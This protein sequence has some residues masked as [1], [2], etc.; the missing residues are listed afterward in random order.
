MKCFRCEKVL[1]V[2]TFKKDNF[3]CKCDY[4]IAAYKPSQSYGQILAESGF[5]L[6]YRNGILLLRSTMAKTFQKM[7]QNFNRVEDSMV[8]DE[9]LYRELE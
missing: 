2:E 4:E 3:I 9:T 6:V 1:V 8:V 5:Y 7:I